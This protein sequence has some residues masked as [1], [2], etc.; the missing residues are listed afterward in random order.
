MARFFQAKDGLIYRVSHLGRKETESKLKSTIRIFYPKGIYTKE[1][2]IDGIMTNDKTFLSVDTDRE[3]AQTLSDIK[4]LWDNNFSFMIVQ[5]MSKEHDNQYFMNRN[6]NGDI[7]R[8]YQ[9]GTIVYKY[10]S[11][12][13]KT[14]ELKSDREYNLSKSEEKERKWKLI[15]S[16]PVRK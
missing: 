4:G 1:Q 3:T 6:K 12:D 5:D 14:Y 7:F 15:F 8:D 16:S 2:F 9:W 11:S 13:G 10:V